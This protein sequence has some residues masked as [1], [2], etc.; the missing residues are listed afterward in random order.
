VSKVVSNQSAYNIT[1]HTSPV[2]W[3]KIGIALDGTGY[4][5]D[6]NIWGGEALIVNYRTFKRA[7][8]FEYGPIPGGRPP[9][10]SPGAWP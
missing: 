1:T 9:F 2:A 10:A 3:Q 7:A 4:G 5:S 6:G 8:H